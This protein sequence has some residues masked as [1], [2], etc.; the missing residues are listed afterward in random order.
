[1]DGVDG[2]VV[3]AGADEVGADAAVPGEGG[4]GVPVA[5][6]DLVSFRAFEGLLRGVVSPPTNWAS[7]PEV[8]LWP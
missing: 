1:M 3:A 7:R 4:Q 5:G 2:T 8:V 6:D